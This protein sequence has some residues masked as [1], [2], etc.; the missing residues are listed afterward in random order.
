[1]LNQNTIKQL[2]IKNQTIED[3]IAREYMQHLFLSTL[4]SQKDSDVFLFKGGTA[5]KIIFESPRFSEDLDFSVQRS[6]AK[7]KL[8]NFFLEAINT[9]LEEGISIDLKE[10]KLTSGGYLGI[11]SY[12]LYHLRGEIQ[13]EISLRQ[14]KSLQKSVTTI[15]SDF[16]PPYVLVFLSLQKI[17]SE[18]IAA[19]LTRQKPRDYYDLYFILRHPQ[20][21]K[22]VDFKIIPQIKEKLLK[23][24]INF[25]SELE[26]L[27]PVSHHQILANFKEILFKELDK[28][29]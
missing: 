15:I 20:L 28:Y 9:I 16:L 23:E 24:K 4:Y 1:M 7:N 2:S 18:K 8:E 21:N 19:L 6:L 3:N 27:L 25:K 10:A 13:I 12:S 26:V 22:Y 5:L 29:E 14:Q 17:V 11:L